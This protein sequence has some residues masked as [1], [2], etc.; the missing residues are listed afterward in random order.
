MFG[1]N[2]VEEDEIFFIDKLWLFMKKCE[3]IVWENLKSVL[4]G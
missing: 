1:L 4:R 2:L 3:N